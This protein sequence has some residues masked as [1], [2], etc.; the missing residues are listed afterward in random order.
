MQ[1]KTIESKLKKAVLNRGGLCV[2]FV[3]PSF[4]GVPDRII[5]LPSGKFAFVETKA[6]GEEMRPLQKRRKRQL[7]ALGFKVYC[8]DKTEKIGDLLDEIQGS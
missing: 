6:P 2:K 5:L 7:E 4:A 8:L 3:S 1:E